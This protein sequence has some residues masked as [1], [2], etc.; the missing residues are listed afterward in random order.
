MKRL[1][2]PDARTLAVVAALAALAL[3]VTLV[4]S[5]RHDFLGVL[6]ALICV[7]LATIAGVSVAAARQAD[8]PVAAERSAAPGPPLDDPLAV[9]A[10]TLDA[11]DSRD[12]LRAVRER[13]RAGGGFDDRE[14]WISDR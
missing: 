7:L 6:M 12:A 1:T 13:R 3:L 14:G 4:V 10:D 11:L 8:E 5:R 2:R 9:D